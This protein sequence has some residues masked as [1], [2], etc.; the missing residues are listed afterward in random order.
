MYLMQG[1]LLGILFGIPAAFSASLCFQRS[2][3]YGTAAGLVSGLG[4]AFGS[5]LYGGIALAVA[6][7]AAVWLAPHSSAVLAATV[8][9]L[10]IAGGWRFAHSWDTPGEESEQG[11]RG[12]LFLSAAVVSLS[13]PSTFLLYLLGGITLSG[14]PWEGAVSW[15]QMV[16]GILIGAFL[17]QSLLTFLSF[18]PSGHRTPRPRQIQRGLAVAYYLAAG[19]VLIMDVG[20]YVFA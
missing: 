5:A 18:Q 15:F 16:A 4:G 13:Y 1:V 19:V 3:T 20:D 2:S 7:A 17:W 6:E 8:L 9:A 14:L 10:A 11:T 12:W